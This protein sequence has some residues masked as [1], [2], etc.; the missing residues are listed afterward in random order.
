MTY[1]YSIA[2]KVDDST[3]SAR[4]PWKFSC[5]TSGGKEMNELEGLGAPDPD[6]AVSSKSLPDVID[7]L[8]AATEDRL[9]SVV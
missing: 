6:C 8:P 2:K 4:P 7:G 1:A 9:L 5:R 3:K